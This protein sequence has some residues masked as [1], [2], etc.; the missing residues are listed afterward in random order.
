MDDRPDRDVLER[1][2]VA[3]LHVDLVAG[4]HGI[5][6]FQALRREDIAQL[7]ILITDERDERGPVG[8]ILKPL[9]RRGHIALGPLEI[10]QTIALL[11]ATTAVPHC[12]ATGVVTAAMAAKALGQF[13]DRLALPQLAAVDDDELP[14]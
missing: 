8:I 7:A 12:D 13:L 1:H 14:L 3:G 5:A 4:N 9:D 6:S 11:M 10:D 2:R